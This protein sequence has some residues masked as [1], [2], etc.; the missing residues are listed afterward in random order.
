LGAF[1][2]SGLQ[3]RQSLKILL[4]SPKI[5][6]EWTPQVQLDSPPWKETGEGIQ[7]GGAEIVLPVDFF[8]LMTTIR[9]SARVCSEMRICSNTLS[10]SM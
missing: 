9:I 3:S 10:I 2:N 8:D 6:H 4:I 5:K 1:P 7:A